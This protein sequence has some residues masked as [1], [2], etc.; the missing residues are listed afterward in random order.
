M[1]LENI[2]C[3]SFSLHKPGSFFE[4]CGI[5]DGMSD[6]K[7]FSMDQRRRLDLLFDRKRL[8]TEKRMPLAVSFCKLVQANALMNKVSVLRFVIL[9]RDYNMFAEQMLRQVAKSSASG[10]AKRY[11]QQL[12]SNATSDDENT[13]CSDKQKLV[14]YLQ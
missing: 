6:F 13:A 2:R 9:R 5:Q 11:K 8:C 1:G 7:M 3:T 4:V 10:R 12:E 14:F